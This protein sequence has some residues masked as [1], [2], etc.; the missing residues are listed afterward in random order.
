MRNQFIKSITRGNPKLFAFAMA[1]FVVT[2]FVVVNRYVDVNGQR[3][4]GESTVAMMSSTE[5]T[6]G[7][8]APPHPGFDEL[9]KATPSF[10]V[11]Q[12][13]FENSTFDRNNPAP[14]VV[15]AVREHR[16]SPEKIHAFEQQV[17][18]VW[19]NR[20]R[21]EILDAQ[22]D[23]IRVSLLHNSKLVPWMVVD[24]VRSTAAYIGPDSLFAAWDQA[25]QAIVG[26]VNATQGHVALVGYN[27]GADN[28]VNQTITMLGQAAIGAR[29]Q[30]DGA[31]QTTIVRGQPG[32]IL[33][34]IEG[35]KGTVEIQ[36][37]ES[38]NAIVLKG[39]PEDVAK[40]KAQIE[41]IISRAT[42]EVG[43]MAMVKLNNT[44]SSRIKR[45]IDQLYPQTY[46]PSLGPVTLI[47]IETDQLVVTGQQRAVDAVKELIEKLDT[48]QSA[49][50]DAAF[51]YREFKLKFMSAFDAATRL[52]DYFS[53]PQATTDDEGL[54][55]PYTVV[56]DLRSNTLVVKG[57]QRA[58]DISTQ[59]LNLWDVDE[60]GSVNIL[61]VIPIRNALAG[62]LQV[63]IQ[64]AINGQIEGAGRGFTASQLGQTQIQPSTGAA[65]VRATMLRLQMIN[66]NGEFVSSGILFDVR[67]TADP[68]S[69]SLIVSAPEKSMPLIEELVRQ[70]DTIPDAETLI[71]VFTIR[72]GDANTL[73]QLL[74]NLFAPAFQ[75]Q[76]QFGGFGQQGGGLSTLPLNNAYAADGTSLVDLRF[77]ADP[78]TNSVIISGSSA[79]L[80]IAEDLLLRLDE[81][82]RNRLI[83]H[84][85]R[86]I[87][88]PVE[89]IS[90]AINDWL[91]QR[92]Q[93]S[94]IDPTSA[95]VPFELSRREVIVAPELVSNS[96]VVSATDEYIDEIERI[97]RALDRRPPMVQI[98]VL[99]AEVELND[100]SEFGIEFGIQDSL[101]FDRGLNTIRYPFNQVNIGNDNTPASLATR[102][103]LAGQGLVNLGV[104]RQSGRF[105]Y[106]GLVL[107]AGNESINVLL[108]AL[109]DRNRVR[110]L[111]AP[112]I[113]TLDNLQ[114]VTTVGAQVPRFQGTVQQGLNT[115]Q[116]V[117]DVPVGI[118]LRVTP[119]V[120][121]DGMIVMAIDTI[122]SSVG[123][124]AEGVPVA[125]DAAGNVIRSPLILSTEAS[126]TVMSR[127]GQSIVLSGL[128]TDEDAWSKRGIPILSDLPWLGPLFAFETK[129]KRRKELLLILTPYL[130]DSQEQLE[131][132]NQA[133]MDRMNWC[134]CDVVN[135]YGNISTLHGPDVLEESVPTIYYPDTDPFGL[136]PKNTPAYRV[137][138]GGFQPYGSEDL[139]RYAPGHT[140]PPDG[141]HNAAGEWTH[142]SMQRVDQWRDSS[143]P[144]MTIP[145]PPPK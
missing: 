50:I 123:A 4:G 57:S 58:L 131:R 39:D 119:R 101:L 8:V 52:R 109:K 13:S 66:G 133:E 99:I 82:I 137:L 76:Q 68:N 105:G 75:Q 55:E 128:I 20:I 51:G 44:N 126:T 49:E 144:I 79:D 67:V 115:I 2:T 89:D 48:A 32:Q 36:V 73:L 125:F 122:K 64:D 90:L 43:A 127:S 143:E 93:V 135:V 69:N 117:G 84:V 120:S 134:L 42:G 97:I 41:T 121:P 102:E 11:V 95:N 129:S 74:Q 47:P 72:H 88:V 136:Q 24:H 81:G 104:G 113:T 96:L 16:I 80:M 29:R 91:A 6:V 140:S 25:M 22:G 35:L 100:A 78:A 23:R 138:E 7:V 71:K 61:K 65:R 3:A 27:E 107:S 59:L 34:E 28:L 94:D 30:D 56:E 70:L 53:S 83:T 108:R 14:D 87:N 21:A 141:V 45:Q 37:I 132:I 130:I 40:V 31:P 145:P 15:N 9:H 112:S 85:Y 54:A 103:N 38:L 62:D 139:Y 10:P 1:V 17:I 26:S 92:R 106:G 46:Q 12:T 118:I 114:A 60:A 116:N 124:E 142:P 18:D 19:G 111:S 110:V 86:I 5:G 77:A 98:K 33:Q 63:V